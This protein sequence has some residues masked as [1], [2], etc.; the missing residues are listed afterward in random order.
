VV[1]RDGIFP[2]APSLDHPGPM[3]RTPADAALLLAAIA[4]DVAPDD[5][6]RRIG[7]CADLH[8]T[9]LAPDIQEAILEGRCYGAC[10]VGIAVTMAAMITPVEI[11]HADAER[12]EPIPHR[13]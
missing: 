11:P 4:G 3:A 5:G 2:L 10:G 8:L 13:L 1:S 12:P 6:R 9:P 7:V